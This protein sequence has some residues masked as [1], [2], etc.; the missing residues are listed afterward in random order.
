VPRIYHVEGEK[1]PRPPALV[2]V[3]GSNL[4]RHHCGGAARIARDEFQAERGVSMGRTNMAYAIP[5]ISQGETLS[6]EAI[7]SSVR[8]FVA[9]ADANPAFT[10]YV[11]RVGCGLA[12]YADAQVAPLFVSAGANCIFSEK[13]KP[14]LE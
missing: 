5:V 13:W 11:V 14:W 6:L 12:G 10:F 2:F 4:E 3:F 7:G 8:E 1:P 9:Y